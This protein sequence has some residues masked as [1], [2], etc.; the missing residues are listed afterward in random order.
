MSA[1]E[2]PVAVVLET[3]DGSPTLGGKRRLLDDFEGAA[4]VADELGGAVYAIEEVVT[5]PP[6]PPMPAMTGPV[7]ALGARVVLSGWGLVATVT[8]V[9]AVGVLLIGMTL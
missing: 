3:R 8:G 2:G 5:D 6:F 4:G 9:T 7:P 1:V